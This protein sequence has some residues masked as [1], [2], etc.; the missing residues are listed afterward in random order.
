MGNIFHIV[1]EECCPE[2]RSA[3]E[4][5]RVDIEKRRLDPFEELEEILLKAEIMDGREYESRLVQSLDH[6]SELVE[7]NQKRAENERK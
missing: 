2:I 4:A 3:P 7:E 5:V 1:M 6:D